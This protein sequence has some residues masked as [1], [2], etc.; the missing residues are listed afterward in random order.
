VIIVGL[1]TS[2]TLR[3]FKNVLSRMKSDC[4]ERMIL[5]FRGVSDVNKPRN[6]QIQQ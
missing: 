4:F 1:F 2:E 3:N 5:K 6:K